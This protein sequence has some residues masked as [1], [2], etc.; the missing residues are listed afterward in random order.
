MQYQAGQQ[1]DYQ[2]ILGAFKQRK[3]NIFDFVGEYGSRKIPRYLDLYI[4]A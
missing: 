1:R 4:W 3:Q 2:K